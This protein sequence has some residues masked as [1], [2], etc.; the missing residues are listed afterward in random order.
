MLARLAA[1]PR[2]VSTLL[3]GNIAPNALV[4]VAAFGLDQ[5]LDLSL[6]AYGSDEADR[7]LLVPVALRRLAA[8][9]GVDLAPAGRLGHRRHPS[10][11]GVRPGGREPVPAGGDRAA[12]AST[13]W[14]PSEPDCALADL[15]DAAAV[16]KLLTGDL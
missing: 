12:T 9:R 4:K 13:S 3:T 2:V 5:W 8:E 16:V 7:N 11:P 6:G 10:G 1:D 15:S 14:R